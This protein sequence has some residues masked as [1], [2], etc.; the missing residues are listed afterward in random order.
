M[1]YK[2]EC[3]DK[4]LADSP[5]EAAKVAMHFMQQG[6]INFIVTDEKTGKMY[7]VNLTKEEGKRVLDISKREFID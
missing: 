3:T 4:A 7:S 5:L 2:V 1:T 6:L